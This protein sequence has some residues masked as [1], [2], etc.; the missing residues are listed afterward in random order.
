MLPRSAP[1][2]EKL[3]IFAELLFNVMFTVSVAQV[4]QAPVGLNVMPEFVPFTVNVPLRA[5]LPPL[6]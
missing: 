5:V 1:V 2:E 4:F 6:A 3:M